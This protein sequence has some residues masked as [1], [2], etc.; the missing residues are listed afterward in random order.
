MPFN[1][2]AVYGHRGWASSAIFNALAASGAPVRVI[3]RPGSD[4][5]RLPSN[6][7]TVPLDVLTADQGEVQ[8]ALKDVDILMY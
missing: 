4:I 2:L 5:S 6:V 7:E 1:R 3:Y 8:A